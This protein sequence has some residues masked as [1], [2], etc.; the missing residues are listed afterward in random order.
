M[1]LKCPQAFFFFQQLVW[2]IGTWVDGDLVKGCLGLGVGPAT[3]HDTQLPLQDKAADTAMTLAA[4][5]EGHSRTKQH[6][7]VLKYWFAG[8]QAFQSFTTCSMS[9]D[10]SRV[11][12]LKRM[13][14]ALA[15][16]TNTAMW[17]CPQAQGNSELHPLTPFST[18]LS[19]RFCFI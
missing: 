2:I 6:H 10:I 4:D 7:R 12:G 11:G 5:D 1:S 13:L 19:E 14:L 15:L 17:L 16:P 3:E 18:T 8:R 9:V